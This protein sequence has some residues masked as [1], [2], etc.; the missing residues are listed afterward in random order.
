MNVSTQNI[1]KTKKGLRIKEC[2]GPVIIPMLNKMQF[3]VDEF[4]FRKPN[5]DMARHEVWLDFKKDDIDLHIEYELYNYPY[6]HLTLKKEDGFQKYSLDELAPMTPPQKQNQLP[7]Q[8]DQILLRLD[9][10]AT[11][12]RKQL[13]KTIST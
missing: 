5:I 8:I 4:G 2:Y 1:L 3:L 10:F 7:I 11:G 6:G 12:I 9:Q 13:N